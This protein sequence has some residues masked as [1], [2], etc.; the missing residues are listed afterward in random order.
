MALKSEF[1][2]LAIM[3]ELPLVVINIQRAGPS[4]GMP[5]K[6]EQSDLLQAVFGRHGDTPLAVIAPATPSDCFDAAIRF[7]R[8][9]Y[10]AGE[11]QQVGSDF[12]AE[13]AARHR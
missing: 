9:S 12:L 6:T 11:P 5:T 7:H 13:R 8:Q 4:T 3:A 10:G 1:L 2:S